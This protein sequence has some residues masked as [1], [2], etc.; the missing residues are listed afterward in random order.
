MLWGNACAAAVLAHFLVIYTQEFCCISRF[1]HNSHRGDT[2]RFCFHCVPDTL[3]LRPAD[4]SGFPVFVCFIY[5]TQANMF[6]EGRN[7]KDI[8]AEAE[9]VFAGNLVTEKIYGFNG[10]EEKSFPLERFDFLRLAKIVNDGY[11]AEMAQKTERSIEKWTEE[12]EEQLF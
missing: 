1:F 8:V 9:I 6:L 5:L 12:L 4:I 11:V 2:H 3:V 10:E 7:I